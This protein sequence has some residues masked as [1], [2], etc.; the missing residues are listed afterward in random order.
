MAQRLKLVEI[1]VALVA[2]AGFVLHSVPLLFVAL[3]LFGVIAALFGPIKYGILPDHL[4]R[5]ELPAGN[6]LVE[7]A[8][9]LAILLGTIVGG[10][11][12]KDGGDPASFAGLMMVFALLCWA[13]EPV[14]P[15]DR[16]R[17]RPTSRST[18][19]SSRPTGRLLRHLRERPRLW[20][21]A[22]VASWF[23]LVGAV[24][25]SLL[26]PLV[27]NVARRRRGGRHRLS[28]RLLDRDRG[29]LRPRRLA[30]RRA[31]RA[32]ADADRRGAARPVR[33]R[34]RLGDL[35]ARRCAIA[36]RGVGECSR[37][38]RGLRV[39]IDLAGLAIAGGL[40]IVPTFAAVQAWAG[41][42]RRARVDRRR[43]RAQR[44]LH[45]RRRASSSRCCR[46]SGSTTPMLFLAASA[47]QRSSVAVADRPDHADQR[48]ARLPV[49]PLPRLLPARGQ[50]PRE[51]RQGRAATPSSRSTM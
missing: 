43:Q 17:R 31:H 21:G 4:A 6:A 20:W 7:G 32:A 26:P 42:D 9:F 12:A 45:G 22:L 36:G 25:L 16:R 28:R 11:A 37:P 34:S 41:A 38:A 15:A 23:W 50:G 33:A 49:D 40:F 24:V 5:A 13:V 3:F 35:P 14:H 8:T 51:P 39:A 10:L 47:S 27:K 18:P 2:V 29:R 48:A 19:T 1:G 44:R 30:R 46:R